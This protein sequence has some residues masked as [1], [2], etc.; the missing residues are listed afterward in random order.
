VGADQRRGKLTGGTRV[1]FEGCGRE[2]DG[3]GE[4]S[5][6]TMRDGGRTDNAVEKWI[7]RR[8]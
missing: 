4:S 6:S 5:I 1:A 8:I 7:G 3:G 2:S